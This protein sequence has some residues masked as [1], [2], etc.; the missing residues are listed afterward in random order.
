MRAPRAAC[1]LGAPADSPSARVAVVTKICKVVRGVGAQQATTVLQAVE[2]NL[3][4]AMDILQS[5]AAVPG[6]PE[7]ELQQLVLPNDSGSETEME[8][9]DSETQMED[10]GEAARL[11]RQRQHQ[12][13]TDYD[14]HYQSDA[15]SRADRMAGR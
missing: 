7:S 2:W 9:E 13:T 1:A 10:G 14:R 12:K 15:N 11:E 3:S 8:D 5:S 6:A 4:R